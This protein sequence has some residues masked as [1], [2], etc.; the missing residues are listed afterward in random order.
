MKEGLLGSTRVMEPRTWRAPSI[1]SMAD[2]T[3]QA[4]AEAN[5]VRNQKRFAKMANFYHRSSFGD[6]TGSGYR[7]S[8]LGNFFPF[9]SNPFGFEYFF[10]HLFFRLKKCSRLTR[11]CSTIL[12]FLALFHN[13]NCMI[14]GGPPTSLFS[15]QLISH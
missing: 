11:S 6:F 15:L 12:H 10:T 14:F 5:T 13:P 7:I 8:G 1:N 3:A 2:F 9:Y 4:E